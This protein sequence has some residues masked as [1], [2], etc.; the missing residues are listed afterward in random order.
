MQDIQHPEEQSSLAK[1]PTTGQTQPIES[2]EMNSEKA[3]EVLKKEKQERESRC[4][5]EVNA[6][7]SRYGCTI[8]VSMLITQERNIPQANIVSK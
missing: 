4:A 6:V 3:I 8:N 5:E 1:I 7:L 2:G